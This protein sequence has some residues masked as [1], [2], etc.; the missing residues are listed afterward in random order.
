MKLFHGWVRREYSYFV[1]GSSL[2]SLVKDLLNSLFLSSGNLLFFAAHTD[3]AEPPRR[4]DFG[5]TEFFLLG[6]QNSATQV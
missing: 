4:T 2:I 3:L 6:T 5:L 1:A